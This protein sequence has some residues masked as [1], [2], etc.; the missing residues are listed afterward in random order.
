MLQ[1]FVRLPNFD[2]SQK[3]TKRG[4]ETSRINK[5]NDL[6]KVVFPLIEEEPHV[7]LTFPITVITIKWV[8]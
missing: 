2:G 4:K 7:P 8:I 1:I 5:T 6:L 3:T